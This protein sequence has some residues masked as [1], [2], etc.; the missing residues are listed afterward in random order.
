MWKNTSEQH[1]LDYKQGDTHPHLKHTIKISDLEKIAA[2]L[3]RLLNII[4]SN[5][6]HLNI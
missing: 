1:E 2:S 4:N 5:L 6:K 3:R